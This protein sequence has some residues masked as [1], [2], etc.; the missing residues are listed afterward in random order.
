MPIEPSYDF[1]T[2]NT[3]GATNGS[4]VELTDTW[5]DFRKKT[6][7]IVNRLTGF[8]MAPVAKGLLSWDVVPSP[9]IKNKFNMR[10]TS[11]KNHF[12]IKSYSFSTGN[13]FT[14]NFE[15]PAKDAYLI[16]HGSLSARDDIIAPRS[17]VSTSGYNDRR[18]AGDIGTVVFHTPTKN[19]IS[20]LPFAANAS[21]EV[22]PYAAMHYY[23][24]IGF[25]IYGALPS[26]PKTI[27][28]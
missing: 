14:V 28:F 6:N 25:V 11:I 9:I 21:E 12:N 5:E 22:R 23:K 4:G 7:G 1:D 15:T 2:F 18:N 10:L 13:G 27:F 3:M 16:P 19:S 17:S 24:T 8:G 26:T 20:F